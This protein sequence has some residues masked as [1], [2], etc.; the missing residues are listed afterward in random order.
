MHKLFAAITAVGMACSALAPP[1]CADI[2][3]TDAALAG[4]NFCWLLGRDSEQYG[5]DHSYAYSFV[6][7]Y[8]VQV[9][10]HGTWTVSHDGLVTLKIDGGGT[11]VR[12]YDVNGEHVVEL[13]GSVGG[14]DNG[15]VC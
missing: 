2:I 14:G 15:H 6:A 1:A 11:L 5:R 9:V 7:S 13:T 4:K 3:R 10:I 12:R 8:S